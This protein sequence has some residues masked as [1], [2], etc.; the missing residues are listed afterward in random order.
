MQGKSFQRTSGFWLHYWPVRCAHLFLCSVTS[1]QFSVLAIIGAK[2]PQLV[3]LLLSLSHSLYSMSRLDQSYLHPL[4]KHPEKKK[5]ILPP[6]INFVQ[7]RPRSRRV[8]YHRTPASSMNLFTWW[9]Y[10]LRNQLL[11]E[12]FTDRVK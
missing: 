5:K 11:M 4:V 6:E 2:E 7:V 8:D 3:S 1:A 9:K 10:Q 12:R